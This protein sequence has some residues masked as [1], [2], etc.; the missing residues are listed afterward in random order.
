MNNNAQIGKIKTNMNCMTFNQIVSTSVTIANVFLLYLFE[1]GV[2]LT[3]WNDVCALCNLGTHSL[4]RVKLS[5]FNKT[6]CLHNAIFTIYIVCS[7]Q[8]VS[9]GSTFLE[10]LLMATCHW[11]LVIRKYY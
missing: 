5:L 7:S 8:N 4:A 1:D 10:S 9:V 2:G 11:Q 6:Y 3:N